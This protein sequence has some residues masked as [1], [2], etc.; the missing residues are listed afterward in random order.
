MLAAVL[1]GVNNS[2]DQLLLDKNPIGATGLQ[3]LWLARMCNP[4]SC[5]QV[6]VRGCQ[7]LLPNCVEQCDPSAGDINIGAPVSSA[8]HHTAL[9]R[10][11]CRYL[12]RRR[13]L[14]LIA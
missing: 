4:V 2:L 5:A 6:S 3:L 8:I 9:Q 1:G 13:L 14:V 7:L 10:P 12:S 11:R